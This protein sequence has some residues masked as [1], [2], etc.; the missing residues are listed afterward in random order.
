MSYVLIASGEGATLLADRWRVP[1]DEIALLTRAS[2]VLREAETRSS[3]IATECAAAAAEAHEQGFQ[4][5]RREGLASARTEVAQKL[6]AWEA[7]AR[8]ERSALRES[9]GAL[10]LDVVR[11][12][13][14]A[15]G[16]DATV[17]A[18]AERAVREVVAE[19]P[20]TVRVAP[21]AVGGVERRLWPLNAVVQVTADPAL[22][23][24]ECTV[25]TPGG[26]IDAGLEVQ[27]AALERA[28]SDVSVEAAA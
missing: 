9:A 2:D 8:L 5:G 12:I 23:P 7:Q 17:Q 3:R 16:P 18:L 6:I 13:T 20:L 14:V 21:A 25:E 11:R 10:A 22:A 4:A 26:R 15:L 1:R 19:Q 24:T 28:F 27:L